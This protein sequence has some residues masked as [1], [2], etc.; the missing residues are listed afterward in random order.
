LV[1]DH[2]KPAEHGNDNSAASANGQL[3]PTLHQKR[4]AQH[5]AACEPPC[6]VDLLAWSA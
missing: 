5:L 2:G 3:F 6:C 4:L 1:V